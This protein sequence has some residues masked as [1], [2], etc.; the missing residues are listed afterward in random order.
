VNLDQL[1]MALSLSAVS[2]R[3]TWALKIVGGADR[4]LVLRIRKCGSDEVRRAV[5]IRWLRTV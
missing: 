5:C 4:L 3:M 2:R 1:K